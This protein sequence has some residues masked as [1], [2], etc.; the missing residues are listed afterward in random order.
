[1]L[2][3]IEGQIDKSNLFLHMPSF[4]EIYHEGFLSGKVRKYTAI[5]EDQ[6]CR[7]LVLNVIRKDEDIIWEA[8][9]DLIKRSVADAAHSVQ[10]IFV[11][12]LLTMDIHNELKTFK[13]QEFTTV[14]MNHCRKCA[15]GEKRLIKYSSCY[16][17]LHRINTSHW[18][19]ITFKT[20]VEVFKDKDLYIDL[21]I[22]Q[23]LKNFEYANDPGIL[24]LNDL[25]LK[26]IFDQKDEKQQERISIMLKKQI[27]SSIEFL[28]EVYVQD[29]NGVMELLSNSKIF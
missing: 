21:L 6:S 4:G 11:F 18:G 23:L 17:I 5:R 20:A 9:S 22:K 16:G 12:D 29:K 25:S 24:L 15:I 26:P 27:P 14:L 13:H 3:L 19:K 8:F 10:G 28:P 7:I 2:N 1:M